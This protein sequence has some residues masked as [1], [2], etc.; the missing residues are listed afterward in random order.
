MLVGRRA[1]R[2]RIDD[3]LAGA[4]AGTSGVLVLR[5]EPG[6]GKTSLL[7]YARER[8]AGMR[9]LHA[10]GVEAESELPFAALHELVRPILDRI[11][12]IPP[13][14]ARAL[15]AA[16]ALGRLGELDPPA[17]PGR[18]AAAAATLSLLAAAAEERPTLCLVDDAHWL[19]A[20]S[21]EALVFACRR[22]SAEGI[23]ILFA[24]RE[25]ERRRFG[26]EVLPAIVLGGLGSADARALLARDGAG[27]L[28]VS[29]SF[30]EL[31]R[32]NPLA[33]LELPREL[34]R[35]QHAGSGDGPPVPVGARI[36]RAFL[37][38]ARTLPADTQRALLVA[39]ASDNGDSG[40]L[41]RAVGSLGLARTALEPAES[42]GLVDLADGRCTFSH[43]LLRSAVYHSADPADRRAAHRSLAAAIGID[44]DRGRRA[45]H[46]AAAAIGPDEESAV[47]LEGA[48]EDARARGGHAAAAS[49]LEQAAMLSAAAPDRARRLFA[50]GEAYWVAGLP[51]QAGPLLDRALAATTDPLRRADVQQ[52]RGRAHGWTGDVTGAFRLLT[53]EADRVEPLDATRAAL[54]VA[55]AAHLCFMTGDVG[56]ALETSDRATALAAPGGGP[57]AMIAAAMMAQAE[58]LAGNGARAGVLL[59]GILPALRASD[60][61]GLATVLAQAAYSLLWIEEFEPARELLGIAVT[62][63]RAQ[64]AVASLPF[65]L[66]TQ[67]ELDLRLGQL[68]AAYAGA[69]E[70]V[71]LADQTGQHSIAAFSYVTLA[72]VEAILGREAD[73]RTHAAQSLELAGRMGT[74]SIRLYAASALALLELGLGHP[75]AARAALD[76]MT[77]LVREFGVGEPS[78]VQWAPDLVESLTQLGRP[79]EAEAVLA[80]FATQA[81]RTGR[82]WALAAA[83]RCRGL[84]ADDAGFTAQFDESLHWHDRTASPFERARTELAYGGRLRRAG[85]RR[86]ARDRLRAALAAFERMGATLWADRAQSELRASGERLRRR[87]GGTPE[88]LTAQELQVA[89][90]V[91]GG[92]TNREAAA[93]LFLSLK[94]IEFHLGNV[95]RKLGVRSRTDL[96]RRFAQGGAPTARDT[97]DQRSNGPPPAE[98]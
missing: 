36:E 32:G 17:A 73:C 96:A 47:A 37:A 67:A 43:P 95:Y 62:A 30:I 12:Q 54:L 82:T 25:E 24:A 1:E 94:T 72:R 75:E 35:T 91:V 89:L 33:L 78:A 74:A 49:A 23:A 63:G 19:D 92:A 4:R 2:G 15:E 85:L 97:S 68:A 29:E 55:E 60:P 64:S 9:V 53:S 20:A 93:Q 8:S 27:A 65:A 42:A 21:A 56:L 83:A 40:P 10:L 11:G 69:S 61:I 88:A 51:V 22:L 57:P 16:L 26:A 77:V 39:A 46:L 6:I 14:Q 58:V 86:P 87:D 80:E 45:W 59:S 66:A 50:A 5:G 18:F 28:D 31:S 76:P 41:L 52:L 98:G 90:I 81:E 13:V 34:R 71:T 70:S 44:G 38:R 79:A 48:A 3:L 84:L 7:E